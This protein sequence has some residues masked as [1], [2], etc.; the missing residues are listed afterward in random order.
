MAFSYKNCVEKGL[1]KKIPASYDK[2]LQSI[3]KAEKWLD[4]AR[5]TFDGMAFDSSVLA[6]YMVM[7]HAARAILFNDGYREKSHLCISRYLEEK[8]VKTAE[9]EKNWIELLDYHREVRHV[10]QYDLSFLSTREDT[11]KGL[12]SSLKFLERMKKLLNAQQT[13]QNVRRIR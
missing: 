12:E 4:E 6:S 1:L 10:N 5:K 8:Y 11:G 7:F 2:A 3:N 13:P 9:L